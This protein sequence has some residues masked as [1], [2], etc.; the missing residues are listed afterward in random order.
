MKLPVVLLDN[1]VACMSGIQCLIL[2]IN[3]EN[4]CV[5]KFLYYLLDLL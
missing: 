1:W 4:T 5:I 2:S 3:S